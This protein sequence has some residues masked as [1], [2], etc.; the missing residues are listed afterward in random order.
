MP[1]KNKLILALDVNSI[2]KAKELVNKLVGLVGC[3]KVGK[4]LFTAVGP[5]IIRY[6]KKKGGFVFLD[7][8]Y[9]DIPSTVKGASLAAV[10]SGVDMFTV[11]ASGGTQMMRAA[12]KGSQQLK[13]SRALPLAVTVLTS[14]NKK[15][16]NHEV[17]VHGNINSHVIHLAKRAKKAGIKGV[18]ASAQ[19]IK[20]IKRVC[21]KEF[22]VVTPGVRPCWADKD[23]QKRIMTPRAALNAGADY[24]VVGRPITRSRS[25]KVAATKILHEIDD[26]F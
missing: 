2:Q 13:N 12:V 7:L 5:D 4:E 17:G 11:H 24:I 22:I 26:L 8:K 23:D 1:V 9:H 14:L 3:F 19:E 25:P 18:I 15:I 16:L 20:M 21:G 6:I 10:N